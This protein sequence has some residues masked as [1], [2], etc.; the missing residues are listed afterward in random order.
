MKEKKKDVTQACNWSPATEEKVIT[1]KKLG[2]KN[3]GGGIV[4]KNIGWWGIRCVGVILHLKPSQY[5]LYSLLY[6]KNDFKV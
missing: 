3:S 6:R 1:R 5:V 2:D 4:R